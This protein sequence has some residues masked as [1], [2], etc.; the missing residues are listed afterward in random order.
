VK[1]PFNKVIDT[2]ADLGVPGLVLLITMAICGWSD[3]AALTNALTAVG[4]PSGLLGDTPLLGILT[5]I[6]WAISEYGFEEIAVAVAK[7]L[8]RKGRNRE[9]VLREIQ[10]YP[11]SRDMNLKIRE[12]VKEAWRNQ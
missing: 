12:A 5:L 6:S 8:Q 2:I 3:T 10:G 11:I 4:G 7:E 9:D 1:I